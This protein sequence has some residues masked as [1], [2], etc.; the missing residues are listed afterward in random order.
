M[1]ALYVCSVVNPELEST[2]SS[3]GA[4]RL[5]YCEACGN[6]LDQVCALHQQADSSP[7]S[8]REAPK[9]VLYMYLGANELSKLRLLYRMAIAILYGRYLSRECFIY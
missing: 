3:V 8:H 2:G 9:V 6:F 4:H 7:L 5:S 1:W